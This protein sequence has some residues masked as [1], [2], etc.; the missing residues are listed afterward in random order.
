MGEPISKHIRV[1][2][3]CGT[4]DSPASFHASKSLAA[5]LVE[6]KH[7]EWIPGSEG[8]V[9]RKTYKC[10]RV[11]ADARVMAGRPFALRG[12]S[13]Q[14]GS[15]LATAAR[16]KELWALVALAA[17]KGREGLL[18]TI[19]DQPRHQTDGRKECRATVRK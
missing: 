8:L 16:K 6:A 11:E 7:A 10:D 18:A 9:L 2:E 1:V 4:A 5:R 14:V 3:Q 13:A 12:L 15:K 19:A 17:I